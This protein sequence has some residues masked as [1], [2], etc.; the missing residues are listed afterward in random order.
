MGSYR[1]GQEEPGHEQPGDEHSAPLPAAPFSP[2]LLAAPFSPELLADLHAGVFS[3]SVSEQIWASVHQD[4]D[5]MYVIEALDAVSARLGHFDE[6]EDGDR[7]A[8]P[9]HFIPPEVA[10]RLDRAL[11]ETAMPA[12]SSSPTTSISS[13]PIVQLTP[14]RRLTHRFVATGVAASV[15][16]ALAVGLTAVL[17]S[18]GAGHEGGQPENVLAENAPEDAPT[19]VVDSEQID[20]S[21]VYDVMASRGGN[22]LTDAGSLRDCLAANGFETNSTVVGSSPLELDG[23]R[24]VMLVIGNKVLGQG[25][26]LLAVS[27]DCGVG[28][29]GTLLRRELD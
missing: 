9:R 18:K 12:T 5:A 7:S 11:A 1:T 25:M 24:G 4:R 17:A 26:T 20:A 22:D 27:S 28:N 3:E 10:E 15:T 13:S 21:V 2:E 19:L 8:E 23:R 6:F 29:P 16:V 14:R